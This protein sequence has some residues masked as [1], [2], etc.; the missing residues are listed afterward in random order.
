ML[1]EPKLIES[2]DL[3]PT[4][5]GLAV[6]DSPAFTKQKDVLSVGGD[7]FAE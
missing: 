4:A 1:G 3:L 2:A 6:P 5:L 7:R